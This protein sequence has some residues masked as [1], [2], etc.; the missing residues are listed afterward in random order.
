M[1][2]VRRCLGDWPP[3]P[4]AAGKEDP[5]PGGSAKA[6][7]K[8]GGSAAPGPPWAG[9]MAAADPKGRWRVAA[10]RNSTRGTAAS[11]R[12]RVS[13]TCRNR[14]FGKPPPLRETP[15]GSGL[16]SR[17]PLLSKKFKNENRKKNTH[18]F[19][20]KAFTHQSRPGPAAS[21]NPLREVLGEDAL[22]L[23]QLLV[24]VPV[25]L[26]HAHEPAFVLR[27]QSAG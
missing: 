14:L 22:A 26:L 11:E 15:L 21:L 12:W 20:E 3:P 6:S 4:A 25:A 13:P 24:L 18:T 27:E 2:W 1:V 19:W 23:V 8:H 10:A 7:G 17:F 16:S 9:Y 5:C